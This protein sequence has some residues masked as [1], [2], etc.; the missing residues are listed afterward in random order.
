M[1]REKHL[2]SHDREDGLDK[3][4]PKSWRSTKQ[5]TEKESLVEKAQETR[6]FIGS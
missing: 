4:E 5:Y 1:Q 3:S 6:E 2:R